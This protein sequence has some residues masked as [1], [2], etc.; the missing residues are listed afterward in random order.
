MFYS[1]NYIP[2][3]INTPSRIANDKITNVTTPTNHFEIVHSRTIRAPRV[4]PPIPELNLNR[5]GKV[6]ILDKSLINPVDCGTNVDVVVAGG[7]LGVQPVTEPAAPC[8]TVDISVSIYYCSSDM[9]ITG[10]KYFTGLIVNM[11]RIIFPRTVQVVGMNIPSILIWPPRP[12]EI[13]RRVISIEHRA[14]I[15]I[16]ANCVS[17]ISQ[18]QG[19]EQLKGSLA[20]TTCVLIIS[21]NINYTIRT[22]DKSAVTVTD[23]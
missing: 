4:S 6:D 8:G 18:Y 21:I 5:R 19:S 14:K 13:T 20:E 11:K 16:S 7:E 15:S 9:K 10:D 23:I 3:T 22:A 12:A 17:C 2:D 1:V